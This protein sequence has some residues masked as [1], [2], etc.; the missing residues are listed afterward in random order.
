MRRGLRYLTAP[1]RGR[2]RVGLVGIG[3]IAA[4]SLVWQQQA[5][6]ATFIDADY[7]KASF[8]AATLKAI[9]PTTTAKASS[10]GSSWNAATGSWATPRYTLNWSASPSGNNATQLY[11]GPGTSASHTIGSTAVAGNLRVAK[12]STG[13]TQSCALVEG[14]VFCWGTNGSGAL[15]LG[16]TTNTNSPRAVGGALAGKTVT[17]V[18]VGTNHAC[19]VAGGKAYCWGLATNGRLGNGS[20]SGTYTT[21]AAV[22]TGAMSGTVTSISAGDAH[23]CAVASGRAYCWGYSSNGRLGNGATSGTFSTPVAV[24]V[25]G[26][27]S[28]LTVTSVSA[29]T[30][31]S[32]AVADGQ[33]FCWGSGTS[34]RL[35][36]GVT[37]GTFSS[38]VAVDTTTGLGGLTVTAI[39]A[40]NTH[41]CAVVDGSAYCW[42]QASNGRLGNSATSGSYSRPTAVNSATMSAGSVTA[43]NAGS[44][45]SC[46]V[47]DGKAYCWGY[48][49]Y[50]Q[51]GDNST[52][53]RTTPVAVNTGGVLGGRTITAISAGASTSCAAG[54]SLGSCWGLGTSGQLGNSDSSTSRVAV[55]AS[56]T[57]PT[58]PDGAVLIGSD[59][60]LVQGSEYYYRLGYGIGTWNAPDS[61]WVKE[62][63]TTRP[64]VPLTASS[65]ASTSL[66]LGWGQVS[67]LGD[68]YAEYV[69]QRSTSASGSSPAT[70]YTGPNLTAVDRGGLASRT[71]TLAFNSISAGTDHTCAVLE[72]AVYCWGNNDNGELGDGTT[73]AR[74][75]PT[76]VTT[77]GVLDGTTVTA[78]S[79]GDN[80]TCAIADGGVF[81]WG[82]NDYGELGNGTSAQSAVPVQAGSISNASALATGYMHTCAI[83]DGT[84]YCWG[85]NSRGQLGDDTNTPRTSPVAVGGLLTGKIVTS[86]AA[87]AAHTCAIA[88]GLAYCWGSDVSGQ[89]GNNAT[90]SG[91]NSS[92]PVAVL[93]SGVLSGLNVTA[94]TAG[95]AHTCVIAG[96]KAFCW[97]YANYG[98]LGNNATNLSAVAVAVSAPWAAGAKLTSLTAGQYFT[99]VAA[100]GKAYCWGEG[101][102]GQLGNGSTSNRS[103][104]VAVTAS[105]DLSGTVSQLAGGGQHTC[106]VSAD[107]AACW[108]ANGSGRLGNNSTTSTSQPVAVAATNATTCAS[109]A[110]LITPNT[111]S[112]KPSTTYYYKV[113]YTV[114]GGISAT[115]GWLPIKTSS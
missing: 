43:I 41:T 23:T 1:R 33:A 72:D 84:V 16:S 78:V 70:I 86:I 36:N 53:Q 61:N 111:C 17:D 19:A 82:Q 14:Q 115:T 49:N 68:S 57:G 28:G 3:V 22:S 75:V 37:T 81:C 2:R 32:C 69:L 63:T 98:Q 52:T 105:G 100:D 11:S 79:A 103:T 92:V 56:V 29:G 6:L 10:I 42:G 60:S 7:A 114:G 67:E 54:G 55:D 109:G 35:G 66:T 112:L 71:G 26:V 113:K 21:P 27:L 104:P 46:A 9:T 62:T 39:S 74:S 48:N 64:A 93:A 30:S 50:S 96:G 73:T 97:G 76:A 24:S 91:N 47:A 83:A 13:G 87:G 38:P 4:L 80:H 59:C 101:T 25:S 8:T 90:G 85:D 106:A 94:V 15:G 77:S 65:K 40:G 31:H 108:G 99:C 58:C 102:S 18:S 95:E 44:T 107:A 5:T 110:S 34:G 12:V 88:D 51:L 45:H 89:L 20:T